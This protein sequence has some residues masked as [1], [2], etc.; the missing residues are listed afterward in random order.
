MEMKSAVMR[1]KYDQ[2]PAPR[3]TFTS[4][5]KAQALVK[6]LDAKEK[7]AQ[8]LGVLPNASNRSQIDGALKEGIRNLCQDIVAEEG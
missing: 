8:A 6:L 3:P 7:I 1:P 4:K 2:T 5:Q